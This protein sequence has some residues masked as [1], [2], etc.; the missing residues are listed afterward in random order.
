MDFELFLGGIFKGI[1]SISI[2]DARPTAI[3]SYNNEKKFS[4]PDISQSFVEWIYT[5][6]VP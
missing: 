4:K 5:K 1:L 2:F 3:L 6:I